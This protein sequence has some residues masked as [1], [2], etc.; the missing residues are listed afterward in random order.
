MEANKLLN[1]MRSAYNT[2]AF[3]IEKS[4]SFLRSIYTYRLSAPAINKS[5]ITIKVIDRNTGYSPTVGFS[6]KSELGSSPTLLNAGRTTNFIYRILKHSP[7]LVS[8]TNSIYRTRNGREH[9]DVKGRILRIVNESD[10]LVFDRMENQIFNSNLVLIDSYMDDILAETLL[11]YYRD[12]ITYC[13]DMV[14]K[15]EKENPMKYDNVHAYSYKYKKF[16]TAIALGMKPA[17]PWDGIDESTGGYI[18]VT[19]EGNVVA[20]HIH[21]RNH[22]ED[23]LLNNTK[24][25]TAST[26][27]HNFGTAYEE[28]GHAYIKLN[29]QV[30]FI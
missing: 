10:D 30:R 28:N 22:F 27:R 11:Y 18:I 19:R 25:D 17:S 14:E 6:I 2:G 8:E 21:N 29:L 24:Y 9:I 4:E 16:L 12:G 7:N 3:S 15:L 5:D 1:E 13:R 26:A 20:Y 23:Y